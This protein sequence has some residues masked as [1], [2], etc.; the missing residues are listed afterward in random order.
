M[1]PRLFFPMIGSTRWGRLAECQFFIQLF[2]FSSGRLQNR[3]TLF[4]LNFDLISNPEQG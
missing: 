2:F 1:L 3:F 4:A